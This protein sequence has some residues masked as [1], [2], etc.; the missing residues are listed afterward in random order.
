MFKT[1]DQRTQTTY[2]KNQETETQ[3]GEEVSLRSH[4]T[5]L[6]LGPRTLTPNSGIHSFIHSFIQQLPIEQLLFPGAVL[7]AKDSE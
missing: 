3:K 2:F 4:S 1:L 5:F 7:V 6:G